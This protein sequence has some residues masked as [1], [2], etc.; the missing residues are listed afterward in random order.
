M[1]TELFLISGIWCCSRSEKQVKTQKSVFHT[2]EIEALSR[3]N[4]TPRRKTKKELGSGCG[5]SG[6]NVEFEGQINM[7]TGN[8]CWRHLVILRCPYPAPLAASS[9]AFRL[10]FALFDIWKLQSNSPFSCK[11]DP[12]TLKGESRHIP[13][14]LQPDKIENWNGIEVERH[15]ESKPFPAL[16]A[17]VSRGPRNTGISDS[18]MAD[19]FTWYTGSGYTFNIRVQWWAKMFY[20]GVGG[21]AFGWLN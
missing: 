13:S 6:G 15:R 2:H 17:A 18:I 3:N 1:V 14:E 11:T 21:E 16:S 20:E 9:I 12:R 5:R 10:V 19:V 8:L 7:Y 4:I